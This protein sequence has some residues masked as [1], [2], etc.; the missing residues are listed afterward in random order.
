[1]TTFSSYTYGEGRTGLNQLVEFTC[2]PNETASVREFLQKNIRTIDIPTTRRLN[3]FH[4]G[5]GRYTRYDVTQ[6]KYAG[7]GPGEGGGWGYIEV[8]EIKSP[9]DDRWGIVIHEYRSHRGA[10]FTEW[11]TIETANAAFEKL[12]SALETEGTSEQLPGFRRRVECAELSPWFYAIGDEQLL[13][14][15][16]FP[17]GLQDDP[18]YRCGQQFV[19]FDRDGI[20]TVKTCM[21]ARFI[22]RSTHDSCEKLP[23]RMVHWNDGS[24]WDE[25]RNRDASPPRPIVEGEQWITEAIHQFRLLLAGGKKQFTI[26][27]GDG[28]S[29]VG[30]LNEAKPSLSSPAGRYFLHVSFKGGP[31][32]AKGWVTFTPTP[33]TPNILQH[34]IQHFAASGKTVDRVEIMERQVERGGKKWAGVFYAP[35]KPE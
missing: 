7:G 32:P 4:G 33:E 9:P 16:A 11:D 25:S 5:Y 27:F 3:I 12:W 20:P 29:F 23:Y 34:V 26:Q 8:L 13:G 21:G 14:D 1:M 28:G 10:T 17:E 2:R 18:V 19:V 24:V 30:R 31:K 35:T 6:H 15:Y 22:P